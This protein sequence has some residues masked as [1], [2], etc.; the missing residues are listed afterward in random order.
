MLILDSDHMS[1]IEW[2]GEESAPLR[3]RLSDQDPN[4]VAT[5]IVNYEEQVRGWMAYIARARSTA[6]Q[7]EGY[8][9]L[10]NHLDNYRQIPVL[11]FDSRA[12]DV[13]DQLR[14]SRIRVG[15]M[16]L[17]IARLRLPKRQPFSLET[18]KTLKRSPAFACKTGRYQADLEL[19]S[20]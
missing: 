3:E 17:K 19:S 14:R 9:R 13:Y 18:G 12:A 16:D 10:R 20:Q 15:V 4:Q 11:D 5:T 7:V 6:A 1:L 8:R 2:G